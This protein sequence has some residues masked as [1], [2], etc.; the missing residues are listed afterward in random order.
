MGYFRK[1]THW[2]DNET[3]PHDVTLISLVRKLTDWASDKH[4]RHT[5][6]KK[7]GKGI[8]PDWHHR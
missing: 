4:E 3:Y 5:G 7:K 2:K 6:E 1:R 8:F